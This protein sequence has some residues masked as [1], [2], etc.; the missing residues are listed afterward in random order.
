[1][2]IAAILNIV[3]NLK[4]NGRLTSRPATIRTGTKAV[5]VTKPAK[6]AAV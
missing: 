4:Q 2:K 5:Q 6:Q 3:E 1:M